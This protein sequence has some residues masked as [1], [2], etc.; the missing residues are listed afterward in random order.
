[1]RSR[2]TRHRAASEGAK[3][4]APD[5]GL[6]GRAGRRRLPRGRSQRTRRTRRVRHGPPRQSG[7]EVASS[8]RELFRCANCRGFQ[9]ERAAHCVKPNT[10]LGVGD[11]RAIP[12][13]EEVHPMHR[14]RRDVQRVNECLARKSSRFQKSQ[15]QVVGFVG[16]CQDR[17]PCQGSNRRPAAAGSPARASANTA[18]DT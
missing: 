18:S 6:R 5:G 4:Q 7:R 17:K 16:D 2:T 12:S 9:F 15:R 1:M 14:S 10:N 11:V 8:S 13:D 3:Q